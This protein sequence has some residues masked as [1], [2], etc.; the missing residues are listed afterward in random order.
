MS[1]DQ[2]IAD[3][4]KDIQWL[5]DENGTFKTIHFQNFIDRK[6]GPNGDGFYAWNDLRYFLF[7][8]EEQL[9]ESRNQPKLGWNNFTKHEHDKVSIEHIYPQTDTSDYWK[10]RFGMFTDQQ[11]KYLKGSLGNLLP[12]SSSINS[13]LQNDDFPD[14]KNT[15]LDKNGLVVRNGYS[16]GSY[17]ELRVAQYEDWTNI[18]IMERGLI[19]LAFMEARWRINMGSKTNKL[20]LLHLSFL[21][22][23]NSDPLI[24]IEELS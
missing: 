6:F 10:V 11:K 24:Q 1:A 17:S 20:S 13:S 15:K 2:V 8:Y 22:N 7:E 9:K 4:N 19:L 21:D 18:H 3:L 5:F 23:T 14:K 16:N 12:L